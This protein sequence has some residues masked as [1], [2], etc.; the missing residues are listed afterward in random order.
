L[1]LLNKK[2]K[3]NSLNITYLDK[4]HNFFNDNKQDYVNLQEWNN[5]VYFYNKNFIKD[6]PNINIIINNFIKSF[7]NL[8]L[9]LRDRVFSSRKRIRLKRLSINR[10]FVSKS[11]VKHLNKKL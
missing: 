1:K 5:S 7:L 2:I 4:K 11:F 9:I 8:T 3:I 10:I 6:L